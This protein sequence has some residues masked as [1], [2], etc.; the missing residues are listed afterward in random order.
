MATHYT[1]KFDNTFKYT[2]TDKVLDGG[3]LTFKCSDVGDTP[4][5]V[6]TKFFMIGNLSEKYFAKITD[7]DTTTTIY[8]TDLSLGDMINSDYI[9]L[10]NYYDDTVSEINDSNELTNKIDIIAEKEVA[11]SADAIDINS[12]YVNN[13]TNFVNNVNCQN[14]K[15]AIYNSANNKY[16]IWNGT[17][18]TELD[19]I[20]YATA[21]TR[22]ELAINIITLPVLETYHICY[23]INSDFSISSTTISY[24]NTEQPIQKI[25]LSGTIVD[26]SGNHIQDVEVIIKVK[27][28]SK[29]NKAILKSVNSI[30]TNASGYFSLDI[31]AYTEISLIIN[32]FNLS[33]PISVEDYDIDI[34]DVLND[35][36]INYT[37]I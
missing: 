6:N 15:F 35:T 13:F 1:F 3:Y 28:Q 32:E 29:Q 26:S 2:I 14:V 25:T 31:M 8:T 36:N 34:T 37:L 9:Y 16:I 27:S 5:T 11:I 18:W 10:Q 20:D 33:I 22:S 24:K 12:V 17:I 19:T 7:Y 4:L 30:F 23:W 21:N